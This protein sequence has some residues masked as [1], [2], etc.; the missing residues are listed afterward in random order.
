MFNLF[1]FAEQGRTSYQEY[2]RRLHTILP[3]YGAELSYVGYGSTAL[4]AEQGQAWDAVL[5]VR[6]PSRSAFGR[7]V[8]G[9]AYQAITALRTSA[10]SAAVLQATV[11]WTDETH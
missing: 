1:R 4:V 2:V 5:L 10:P 8:A 6:N 3:T 11:P 7:M 9:P